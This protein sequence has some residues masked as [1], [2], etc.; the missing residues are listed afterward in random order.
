M[1]ERIINFESNSA[2]ALNGTIG[3]LS[4]DRNLPMKNESQDPKIQFFPI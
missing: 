1:R 3:R 4:V 2:L